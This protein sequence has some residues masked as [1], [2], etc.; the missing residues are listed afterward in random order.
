MTERQIVLVKNTWS[1]VVVNSEQAGQLFYQRLF[2]VAPAVR[3]MFT[4]DIKAQ[5]RKLMN[6]VTLIVTKLHKLDD[7]VDEIKMLAGRHSKYGAKPEHYSV[8]GE[9]LLWTLEKGLGNRWDAETKE[10]W[11]TVYGILANAMITN[12]RA[13]ATT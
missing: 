6:M 9:C 13:A 8:V 7:V 4:G 3:P 1:Y 10:A 2:E 11:T 12:Q 5:A